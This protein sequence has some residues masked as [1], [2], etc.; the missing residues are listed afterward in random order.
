V[1]NPPPFPIGFHFFLYRHRPSLQ[2][3]VSI[4]PALVFVES[5]LSAALPLADVCRVF[6]FPSDI[7]VLS[8][9]SVLLQA[10]FIPTCRSSKLGS[11]YRP[12]SP[13]S[14]QWFKSRSVSFSSP[15]C[16]S[17]QFQSSFK[18]STK[19]FFSLPFTRDNAPRWF[20]TLQ[21]RI[22]VIMISL[23][24]IV[25]GLPLSRHR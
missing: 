7:G 15:V 13:R 1:W 8:A 6:L 17:S 21:G 14:S 23:K 16:F 25:G 2:F 11:G 22:P 10:R 5:L 3:P 19:G 9:E 12:P 24:P 20:R 18:E 4:I